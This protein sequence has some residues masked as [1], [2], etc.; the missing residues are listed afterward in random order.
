MPWVYLTIAGLFEVVWSTALKF[1][2]G[3]SKFLPSA[4]TIGGM[5][6]SFYF[7][8]LA[9]KTL[10]LGTAYAIWTG[11]GAAGAI[12]FGAVIFHEP[13]SIFSVHTDWD[14]GPETDFLKNS[15]T[16]IEQEKCG[17]QISGIPAECFP[18]FCRRLFQ[19]RLYPVYYQQAAKAKAYAWIQRYPS[20][21]LYGICMVI[22]KPAAS[23]GFQN[24]ACQK[25][26]SS[27][28]EHCP[29]KN[30]QGG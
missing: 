13:Y 19:K 4:V 27:R 7:L 30:Q 5:V 2:E 22:P 6:V 11:I 29:C 26:H 9:T 21:K 28:Q 10:P 15:R 20:V 14:T 1:S 17:N 12:L 23:K 25:L 8:S 3:F 24:I 18:C 16:E